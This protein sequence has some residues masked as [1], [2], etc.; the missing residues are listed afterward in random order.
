VNEPYNEPL[1]WD[2]PPVKMILSNDGGA[3]YSDTLACV[4]EDGKYSADV[5]ARPYGTTMSYYFEVIDPWQT[6]VRFPSAAPDTTYQI[7]VLENIPGD[8]NDDGKI[9]IF[10]VLEVLKELANPVLQNALCDVDRNDQVNIF[11][12]LALLKLL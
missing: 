3:N 10:D 11:D 7:H 1:D 12:I 5:P 8:A 4:L 2:T 6:T 9:D